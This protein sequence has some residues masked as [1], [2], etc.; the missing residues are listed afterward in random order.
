MRVLLTALAVFVCLPMALQSAADP[1][2]ASIHPF[3][4]ERG[5]V[6]TATVRGTGLA[7]ARSVVLDNAPFQVTVDRV[8]P[9]PAD[10]TSVKPKAPVDLVTLRIQV[11][12][13]A[14]PG[15]YPIRLITRGGISNALPIYIVDST[16]TA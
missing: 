7:G 8:E 6:F 10:S 11:A 16:V 4:G 5:T 2:A 12:A 15:R 3:T 14:K 9:E 13:D 1:K